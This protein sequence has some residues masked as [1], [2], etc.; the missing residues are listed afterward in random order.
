MDTIFYP[1]QETVNSA[2]LKD[3][4]LLLLISNDGL[5]L[6]V[7]NIEDAGEHAILLRLLGLNEIDLDNYFRLIVDK[8]GA[9]WTFVCPDNYK[10]ISDKAYRIRQFYKDGFSIIPGALIELGYFVGIGI[11]RR[12]KRHIY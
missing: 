4:T 5:K 3:S 1:N 9:D 11:P 6:I 8:S 2:M 12:Y 10:G 7:S